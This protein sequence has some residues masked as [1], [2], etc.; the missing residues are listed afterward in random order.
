MKN[1]SYFLLLPLFTLL[2]G[3]QNDKVRT[4]IVDTEYSSIE[5]TANKVGGEHTGLIKIKEGKMEFKEWKLVGGQLVLDMAKISCS[6]IEEAKTNAKLVEHLK[7]P[8]FFHVEAHPTAT[9]NITKVVPYG[10]G[11]VPEGEE[12][13]VDV[14]KITGDLT[15]KGITKTVKSKVEVYSYGTDISLSTYLELDRSDF[16]IRYGSGSFFED[17]GDKLIYDEVELYMNLSPVV[18]TY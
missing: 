3:F 1:L 5:W 15:I 16:D 6:D 2:V 4:L 14:Y 12:Y 9:F 17:L 8:D 11:E 7:S 18:A 10:K 13:E